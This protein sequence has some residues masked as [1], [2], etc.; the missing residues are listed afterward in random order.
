MSSF[1]RTMVEIPVIT[2]LWAKY[3]KTWKYILNIGLFMKYKTINLEKLP[4]YIKLP[5]SFDLHINPL[6]NRG[7]ALLISSGITQERLVK[8][9]ERSV[10]EY[11]PT[12]VLDI[13]VNYGEC[14]FSVKYP[15]ETKVYGVEANAQLIPFI[16]KSLDNHPN[17]NQ[18]QIINAF[19]SN[20]E[21]QDQDFYIDTNWSGTSSGKEI[22][23]QMVEKHLVQTVTVDS[24]LKDQD[25]SKERILFKIDVEGYEAF[26]LEGMKQVINQ[27][28]SLLGIIEFDSVYLQNA[29]THLDSFLAN[30]TENFTVYL[31]DHAGELNLLTEV[32]IERIQKILKSSEIHID[33]VLVKGEL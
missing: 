20:L 32:T 31:F 22:Y 15:T 11:S 23:S 3:P 26:V 25:V 7:R 4:T 9:W 5:S 13:G 16:N 19:A 28:K 27:S 10:K 29:G 30:L 1:S 2:K 33:L 17:K 12:T 24:L 6:E 14:L 21:H 8:F 18:I